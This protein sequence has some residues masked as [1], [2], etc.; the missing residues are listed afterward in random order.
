METIKKTFENTTQLYMHIPFFHPFRKHCKSWAP[1]LNVPK[2]AETY[3][4]DTGFASETA[5]GGIN[6]FQLFVDKSSMRTSVHGMQNEHQGPDAL[7]DFIRD[8]GA[9]Y[10]IRNDNF[11]M[12]TSKAWSKI[13]Q[14]YNIAEELSL[15]HI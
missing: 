14:K 12:Q 9:P 1:Q 6:C 11:K 8:K 13:L 15:I 7:E 2:L 4:T 3:A 10:V 5:L